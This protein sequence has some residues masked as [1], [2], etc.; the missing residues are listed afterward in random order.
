MLQKLAP[1]YALAATALK[2][3]DPSIILGKVRKALGQ[4]GCRCH[5]LAWIS[6]GRVGSVVLSC[7]SE[8]TVDNL[9]GELDNKEIGCVC[10]EQV[11]ATEEKKTGEKFSVSGYPTLKWFVKGK[12]VDYNGPRDRCIKYSRTEQ[13]G[14]NL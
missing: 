1:E 3:H 2:E 8:G 12:P 9:I 6:Q 14:V 11:D 13:T 5:I 4:L 10:A 7:G